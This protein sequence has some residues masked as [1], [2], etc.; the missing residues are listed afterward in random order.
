SISKERKY[1]NVKYIYNNFFGFLRILKYL[2][3]SNKIFIHGFFSGKIVLMLFLQPWLLKK[4]YWIIWGAD[5]Y[6]YKNRKNTIK[7]Y[8]YEF[9]RKFVI[10]NIGGIITH[11][12]GDY[13]LARKWYGAKGK[14]Y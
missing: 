9:V 12:K 2:Y 11:I 13:E 5:L 7:S 4:C 10:K 8:I 1:N 6:R 14:Y 3:T